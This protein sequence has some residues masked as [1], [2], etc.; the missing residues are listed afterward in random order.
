MVFALLEIESFSFPKCPQSNAAPNG[1]IIGLR[2]EIKI[3]LN[4]W[5]DFCFPASIPVSIRLVRNQKVSSRGCASQLNDVLKPYWNLWIKLSIIKGL[6]FSDK[7]NLFYATET[8]EQ[9]STYPRASRG[10][11]SYNPTPQ[12]PPCNRMGW[13]EPGIKSQMHCA[14]SS[15]PLRLAF[16]AQVRWT[17]LVEHSPNYPQIII[18]IIIIPSAQRLSWVRISFYHDWNHLLTLV[19]GLEVPSHCEFLQ[20]GKVWRVCGQVLWRRS[21]EIDEIITAEY[22]L[23]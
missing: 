3:I 1:M 5:S 11:V 17:R 8:P 16:M 7:Y 6:Q 20:F 10:P 4:L 15:L 21:V 2:V 14:A 22:F 19:F 9:E 23:S 18:I 12:L 13:I